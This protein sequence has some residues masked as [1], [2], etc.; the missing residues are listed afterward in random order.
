M[1]AKILY[2]LYGE[3]VAK[4][5]PRFTRQGRA[6]TPAKTKTYEDEVAVMAKAAMHCLEPLTTPVAVFV[7][8]T[9]AVPQSYS[10]KRREACLEGLERH[11]KRPDLDNIVKAITD[12]MNGVVYEDDSQIVSLHATKVY[13]TDAMVEVMVTEQLP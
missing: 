6:Y 11:V 1:S 13:G 7:Y 12:G 4:G 9:F 2:K 8:V 5:R 3:P 10:K